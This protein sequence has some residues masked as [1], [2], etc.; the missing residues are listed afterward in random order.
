MI[1]NANIPQPFGP[2]QLQFSNYPL[3]MQTDTELE[4]VYWH[5]QC[6]K[7]QS[8]KEGGSNF[9]YLIYRWVITWLFYYVYYCMKYHTQMYYCVQHWTQ[10]KY[11]M[12]YANKMYY[13]IQYCESKIK[14]P[15]SLLVKFKRHDFH[16]LCDH[17]TCMNP[18]FKWSNNL[19]VKLMRHHIH[20]LCDQQTYESKI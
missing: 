11:Y 15:S 5:V 6:L 7:A 10:V 18:I 9:P 19:L 13:F 20:L 3:K 8:K 12:Q 14:C 1:N 17:Q 4:I 16:L 2:F